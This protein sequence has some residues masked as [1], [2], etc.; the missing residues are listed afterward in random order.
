MSSLRDQAAR[1][2]LELNPI[3]TSLSTAQPPL[4]HQT[5]V[6]ALSSHSLSA[7][8]GY[9]P[10]A[11]TPVTPARQYNPQLWVN[12][13]SVASEAGTHFS[14]PRPSD[15]EGTTSARPRRARAVPNRVIQSWCPPLLPTPRR[16]VSGHR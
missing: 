7:P 16:G 10:Q 8:F 12:S 14:T 6:S 5:P 9:N 1:R 3:T 13:P 2:R 15:R 11:Y 4:P